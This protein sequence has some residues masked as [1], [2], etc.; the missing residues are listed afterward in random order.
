MYAQKEKP[1]ENKTS[2]V[3]NTVTQKQSNVKQGVGFVDNRPEVVAQ[4]KW[5]E[6]S[7]NRSQ[8]VHINPIQKYSVTS[9]GKMFSSQKNLVLET[10]MSKDFYATDTGFKKN[11]DALKRGKVKNVD[12][13][14]GGTKKF[15]G[16]SNESFSKVIPQFKNV[17]RDKMKSET[18]LKDER[19]EATA[20]IPAWYNPYW[21]W[22]KLVNIGSGFRPRFYQ[23]YLASISGNE[24]KV[25][26]IGVE[27][28][29]RE[30]KNSLMRDAVNVLDLVLAKVCESS[31][32]EIQDI[33]G[34]MNVNAGV[35]SVIKT[36]TLD[37][38]NFNW[39]KQ[40]K[41][42]VRGGLRIALGK[43]KNELEIE[44]ADTPDSPFLPTD[45]G[46]M[47]SFLK[48]DEGQELKS[49][50]KEKPKVGDNYSIDYSK[51]KDGPWPYHYATIVFKDGADTVTL[52]DAAGQ[53]TP[54]EKGHWYFMMYGNKR[55]QSFKEKTDSEFDRRLKISK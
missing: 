35:L 54:F 30:T 52:E 40:S 13:S 22:A 5:Q 32:D 43:R 12:F 45:C 37:Y 2:A 29:A 51:R 33:T 25:H 46:V 26:M 16:V 23:A 49:D 41:K 42:S 20:A 48:G 15:E 3:A 53:A 28:R 8:N 44:L 50:S 7:K 9:D 36:S 11:A 27:L 18:T 47:S 39:S 24:T 10:D 6:L 55:K 19:T 14:K 17:E 1:A 4:R 34:I 38:I 31:D 21:L